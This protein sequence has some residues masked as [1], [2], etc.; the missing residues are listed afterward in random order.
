MVRF[1][2]GL[3]LEYFRELQTPDFHMMAQS[4]EILEAKEM[5]NA[6]TVSSFPNLKKETKEEIR[7]NISKIANKLERENAKEL[8]GDEIASKLGFI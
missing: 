4:M 1:Y 8:S 5:L 2:N 7:G 6:L 3:S